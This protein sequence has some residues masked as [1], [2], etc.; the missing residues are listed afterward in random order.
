MCIFNACGEPDNRISEGK[1]VY[2]IE[3]PEIENS[4][5]KALMPKTMNFY[6]RDDVFC[7]EL[8]SGVN[9]FIMKFVSDSDDKELTQ[10]LKIGAKKLIATIRKDEI[11]EINRNEYGVVNITYSN[12]TKVIAGIHCKKAVI[13]FNDHNNS[14]ENVVY[15]TEEFK[16]K[17]PNWSLPFQ[18]IEGIPLQ[19]ELRRMGVKMK[20]TASTFEQIEVTDEMLSSPENYKSVPYASI[21]EE[22]KSLVDNITDFEL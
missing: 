2:D 21:E 11:D 10:S 22:I 8:S 7:S 9:Q 19:Y 3:Y 17:D 12:E 16:F 18:K 13:I 15:Y 6:F 1:I 20:F 5:L 4:I 14:M